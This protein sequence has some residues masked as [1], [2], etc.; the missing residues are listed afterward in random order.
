MKTLD[1]IYKTLDAFE[2]RFGFPV[3]GAQ[4][5]SEVWF[6][7]KLGVISASNASKVVAGASTDTRLTYMCELVAQVCTGIMEELN[8]KY[9]DWGNDH[10]DAARSAYEFETGYEVTELPFV[11]KD[12]SFREGCSPDGF[13]TDKKGVEIK[14]P[15]N[16]V[17]YIKFL[18]EDK[19]KP[20]YMW[21][22]Q[23]TLRVLG[24]DEWDFCQYDP[25]MKTKP[26]KVLTIARDP[27]KQKAFDDLVPKFIEDMDQ[28]LKKV[29]VA[30]GDQWRR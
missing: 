11:Y 14:C 17:H 15:F 18:T 12:E 27:E 3:V 7:L 26:T 21:Q 22:A 23:Y 8:S 5:K 6:K 9:C 25:R 2:K 1:E 28:M 4:Q 13:V 19:I 16:S 20:D 10:E 24:A 29:G 30:F